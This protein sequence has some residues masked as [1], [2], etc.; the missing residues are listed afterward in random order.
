MA[1]LVEEVIIVTLSRLVKAGHEGH[2]LVN[3]ELLTNIESIVQEL[4]GESAIVEV[5]KA[6]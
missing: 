1:K 3:S 6:E 5:T 4:A 2:S